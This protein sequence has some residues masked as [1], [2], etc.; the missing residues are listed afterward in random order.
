MKRL[1]IATAFLALGAGSAHAQMTKAIDKARGA[2]AKADAH[3]AAEQNP[4]QQ[5]K[6][7]AKAPAQAQAPTH[8]K[9]AP[10]AQKRDMGGSAGGFGTG[11]KIG[12][13]GR[14]Q[15]K[16][17]TVPSFV[18]REAFDYD[19]AGTRDPFASL[20]NTSDLRPVISDLKLIGVLYDPT[21]RR[22]VA[23]MRDQQN[24]LYR[25]TLGQTLGR[26]RVSRI[27][28]RAVIFTIEEFGM[29][30]QDSLVLVDTTKTRIP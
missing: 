23:I 25:A 8:V 30:R 1:V 10:P 20:L 3:I 26:M 21:G 6:A 16:L 4:S 29:N 19:R 15:P 28:P 13:G 24:T 17:D 2:K 11:G 12:P 18:M 5:T 22:S 9:A 14:V 7:P 27:E